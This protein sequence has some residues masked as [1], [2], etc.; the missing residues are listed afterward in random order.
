MTKVHEQHQS[1]AFLLSTELPLKCVMHQRPLFVVECIV[2][3]LFS[4]QKEIIKK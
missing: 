4:C 2:F 3:F 1:P